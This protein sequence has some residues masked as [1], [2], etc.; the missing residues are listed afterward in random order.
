[1]GGPIRAPT[2]A[3]QGETA[4]YHETAHQP[5]L[6]KADK[7][8]GV[9]CAII[10]LC[11]RVLG[12]HP[13]ARNGSAYSIKATRGES[14]EE[15]KKPRKEEVKK[16]RKRTFFQAKRKA[17]ATRHIREDTVGAILALGVARL[18]VDVR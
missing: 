8:V 9:P 10:K 16:R 4:R 11:A 14:A 17:K 6:V 2:P 3:S 13:L 7:S 5:T 1:M 18:L 12:E 15:K